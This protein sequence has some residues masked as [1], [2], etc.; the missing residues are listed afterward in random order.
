MYIFHEIA[1]CWSVKLSKL[2]LWNKRQSTFTHSF[3]NF[4]VSRCA[5]H[6]TSTWLTANRTIDRG[7]FSIVRALTFKPFQ[8]ETFQRK[9]WPLKERKLFFQNGFSDATMRASMV[10]TGPSPP[11]QTTEHQKFARTDRGHAKNP[12]PLQVSRRYPATHH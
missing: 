8:I 7:N 6:L 9:D 4:L 11:H 5:K 1:C 12:R 3:S 10:G 2:I